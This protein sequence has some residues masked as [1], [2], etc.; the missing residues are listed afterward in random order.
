M[1][2]CRPKNDEG[3]QTSSLSLASASDTVHVFAEGIVSTRYNERDMAISSE[4]DEVFFSLGNYTQKKRVI[5]HFRKING[6]WNTSEIMSWSG[7]YNDIEPFLA[8]DGASLFFA[9]DRPV[10]RDSTRKDFNI[11]VSQRDGETWKEPV[12]LDTL[13]NSKVDEFYPSSGKSGNLYFT[14]AHQGNHGREDIYIAERK[15]G[16]YAAPI[17]LDTAIN[18]AMYEFNAYV[19]PGEDTIIFSSYGRKDDMGGGDLYMSTKDTGGAWQMAHNLGSSINSTSLD[20]C[21]FIDFPRKTFYF[22]SNRSAAHLNRIENVEQL[23]TEAD[24][25]LNGLDNIYH[26]KMNTLK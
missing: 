11:W 17:P 23:K 13:I 6:V 18:S 15:E 4:G 1:M 12:A 20:Y 5:A 3:S 9:S 2:A 19:S 8:P 10:D 24:K 7:V 21:P 16:K 22:T 25:T 26:V 14:A